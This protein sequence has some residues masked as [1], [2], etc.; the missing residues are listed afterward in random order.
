MVC[1]GGA[2]NATPRWQLQAMLHRDVEVISGVLSRCSGGAG[3]LETI[4]N[5]IVIGGI[6][7]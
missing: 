2:C 4:A 3:E 1:V 7:D 6:S 5:V